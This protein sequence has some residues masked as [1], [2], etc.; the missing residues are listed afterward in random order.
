[1]QLGTGLFTCQQRPDDPR[2][3]PDI[4]DE[5]LDLARVVDESALDSAWL[6]EHHFLDDGYLS[7]P[8]P[9]LGALA[10]ETDSIELGTSIAVAPLYDPVRLAEDAAVLDLLSDGR[11]TVG[12]GLGSNPEELA[13]FGIPEDERPARLV[14]TVALLRDAWS[15]GP[16]EVDPTYHDVDPGTTITPK[17]SGT[18]PVMLGGMARPA[19]RRAA[20]RGDAWCAPSLLSVEEIETRT[21]HIEQVREEEG[22]DEDF[23]VYVL[24]HGF[25]GDS[26]EDAWERMREGYLYVQRVYDEVFT[27]EPVDELPAERREAVKDQAI[28]GT[29]EQV[30]AELRRYAEA[31]GDDVHVILRTYHPGIG[32]DA[33]RTCIERL[34]EEVVPRLPGR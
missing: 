7:A 27:G 28:F 32:T 29:P 25:V 8:L 9:A 30:S 14:D 31:V 18:P 6:S 13:A 11:L 21:D 26:R 33:M 1:M 15:D 22:L 24:Q 10:A 34:S 17:P 2:S 23:E 3:M 5:M 20:L 19:V 4:Y 12:L 16:L